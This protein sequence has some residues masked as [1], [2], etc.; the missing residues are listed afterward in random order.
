[1]NPSQHTFSDLKTGISNHMSLLFEAEGFSPLVGKIFA[2]LLFAPAPL[3][4][5]DMADQLGVSKAAVS[6]QVRAL[7]KHSMCQ[8]LATRSDRKDYYYI[9]EDFTM[10]VARNTTQKIKSIQGQIQ[11]TLASMAYLS[12]IKEEE[13]ESHDAFKLRF[14]EM[15]ALYQAYLNRLEGFE[16]EWRTQRERIMEQFRKEK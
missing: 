3:S 7:E 16:E 14:T 9:A 15:D 12:E 6:V 5:Q 2:L 8:K 13:Q 1:M 4:L 11:T 10:T